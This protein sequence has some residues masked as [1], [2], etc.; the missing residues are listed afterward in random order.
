MSSSERRAAPRARADADDEEHREGNEDPGE[1]AR[2]VDLE[3][4]TAV[5]EGTDDDADERA[6]EREES[7]RAE[8]R[9]LSFWNRTARAATPTTMPA[10]MNAKI[11]MND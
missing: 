3:Q 7:G 1:D 10:R 5:E 4:A 8:P 9:D 6:R 2:A 11:P